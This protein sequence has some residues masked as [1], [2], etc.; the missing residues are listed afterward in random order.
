MSDHGREIERLNNLRHN[1]ENQLE[2]VNMEASLRLREARDLQEAT[3]RMRDLQEK[4]R[5]P[6]PKAG[7]DSGK[8]NGDETK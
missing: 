8:A 7:E 4:I 2:N 5:A 1:L 3:T 6:Q